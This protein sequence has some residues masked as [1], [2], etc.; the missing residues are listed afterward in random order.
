MRKGADGEEGFDPRELRPE[1]TRGG[2]CDLARMEL[3]ADPGGVV[4]VEGR[5]GARRL[6]SSRLD[7]GKLMPLSSASTCVQG[8]GVCGGDGW[9]GTGTLLTL[10]SASPV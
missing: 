4:S 9:V 5:P 10:S 7:A 8:C 2:S 1:P 3:M 6:P